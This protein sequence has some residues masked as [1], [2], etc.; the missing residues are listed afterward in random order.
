MKFFLILCVLKVKAVGFILCD[1][2]INNDGHEAGIT[3]SIFKFK[4]P[5]DVQIVPP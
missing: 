2:T 1:V 3:S 4:D 5:S